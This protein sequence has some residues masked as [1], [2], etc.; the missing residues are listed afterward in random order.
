ML[1]KEDS[2]V[3]AM[4]NDN[5]KFIDLYKSDIQTVLK[6]EIQEEDVVDTSGLKLKIVER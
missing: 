3:P 2:I 1:V 5:L 4:P 6:F